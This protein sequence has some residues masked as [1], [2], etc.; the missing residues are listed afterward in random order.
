M[1]P[2]E[3][4]LRTFEG[5]ETDRVPAFCAMVE[6][7]TYN[8]VLGKPLVSQER[9]LVNP[10]A[11]FALDRWGPLLTKLV[12]QH[13]VTR[14]MEKR[15]KAQV[16]LGF[17]AVWAILDE[18]FIVTDHRTMVRFTGSRYNLQPDG[19]GNMT[20]MYR[21]P[22]FKTREDFLE[23][24]YWPDA[25]DVAHSAY[26]FFSAMMKKYG[27]RACLFGQASA[28]GI[29]ESLLWAVGFE[30]LPLW[31]RRERDLVKRF[32]EINEELCLKT[33]MALL[34][35]G[36]KVVIQTDDF[37]FK[38]GPIM[39]PRLI[40]ELFGPSYR[41]II[42][43]V[44]DRNGKYVLHSCGD[45]TL[46]FDT[47]ISWGVDGLHAYETTSN[48]DIFKEKELHG[49]KVT[50]IGGVGVDYLLTD[51]SRDE[52]VVREVRR[53]IARLGPSGRFIISPVHSLSTIPAHKL[54][55]MVDA[56]RTYG[57]YPLSP[58]LEED[59]A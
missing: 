57:R 35:A 36:V 12:F 1:H 34:D 20:Y 30:R 15:I 7:R 14:S 58:A 2:V 17:D 37:A 24:P 26:R 59:A 51:R 9:L 45:N 49:D 13:E 8:E 18:T 27:H 19:Y 11:T 29:Q 44:H 6:G 4:V 3:R 31:I 41:R 16:E 10:V 38:S 52:E 23:W 40:D 50:I 32:I 39:N 33:N 25:D 28:Y 47:F 55:V 22:C 42:K 54:R 46:L 43:A 48:V 53:L 56:V 21:E 5:K